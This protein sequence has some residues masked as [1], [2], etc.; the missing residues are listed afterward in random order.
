MDFLLTCWA[1]KITRHFL[2]R[3]SDISGPQDNYKEKFIKILA[4]MPCN[5]FHETLN[6]HVGITLLYSL[7]AKHLIWMWII[8][9]KGPKNQADFIEVLYVVVNAWGTTF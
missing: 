9:V 7:E 2:Q 5:Y 4:E 6:K 1:T 3:T 8:K